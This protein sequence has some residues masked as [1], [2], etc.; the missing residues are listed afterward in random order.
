ML[1]VWFVALVGLVATFLVPV[2]A[3][4]AAVSSY[5]CWGYDGCAT[6]GYSHAGYKQASKTMWWRMYSGHNCTNYVAYRMIQN[7][8]SDQ[9][10]WV[11][12]GNATNW[13]I[14]MSS[15]TDQTPT[16]GSVAWWK[17]G[18]GGTGSAGHVAY[19][20]KVVSST[21]IIVSQDSW[22]GDFSWRRIT[23]DSGRWP[24]GFIHFTDRTISNKV[25]PVVNGAAQVGQRLTVNGAKWK[26][27]PSSYA[28]QWYADGVAIPGATTAA[29]VVGPEQVGKTLTARVTA[30]RE[31]YASASVDTAATAPVVKGEFQEVS[32]PT[33][34]GNAELDATLTV[35]PGSWSP[36]P[37]D[38]NVKW[39][40][41]GKRIKDVSGTELKLAESQV[42][43]RIHAVVV[44]KAPGYVKATGQS[45]AS[46]PVVAGS[47]Q[48]TAATRVRGKKRVGETLTATPGSVV[49]SDATTSI[50]WLRNGK[51]VGSGPTYVVGPGDLGGT[52]SVT[53]TATRS[54]YRPAT[55]RTAIGGT[56]TTKPVVTAKPVGR[57]GVAVVKVRVRAPG[58]SAP[59][60]RVAVKVGPQVVRVDLVDGKAKV[61]VA[62]LKR[63]ERP[64]RVKYLRNGAILRA[65]A[66]STV[67]IR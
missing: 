41:D 13:G 31:G 18:Q 19:V 57:K 53:T 66:R 64:V 52:L 32:G 62:G 8:Y 33:L 51:V 21:E 4:S 50:S 28:R 60:G 10:P 6:A 59:D 35:A 42:D 20:E 63:G 27:K 67:T 25:A 45:Q 55:S 26:N 48:F 37:A 39:F 61:R 5:L 54:S 9:R 43:A 15:I 47:I 7:G 38:L 46:A 12:N 49:P 58:V 40:A 23:K 24:S 22:G 65:Y 29:F 2:G 1:R 56:V 44:A 16:V 14:A 11:G 30:S 3:G 36:A 34:S 17:A